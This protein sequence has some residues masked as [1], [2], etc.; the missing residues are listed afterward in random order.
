MTALFTLDDVGLSG[1]TAA[2]Q[3]LVALPG[4]IAAAGDQAA[5]V[6]LSWAVT[7][8]CTYDKVLFRNTKTAKYTDEVGFSTQPLDQVLQDAE[9]NSLQFLQ[10]FKALGAWATATVPRTNIRYAQT[11]A[12]I[13]AVQTAQAGGAPASD[14]QRSQVLIALTE[15]VSAL[16]DGTTQLHPLVSAFATYVLQQKGYLDKLAGVQAGL[17]QD[18]SA[19]LEAMVGDF[20]HEPCGQSDAQAQLDVIEGKYRASVASFDQIFTELAGQ[21]QAATNAAGVLIGTIENFLDSYNVA[22]TQVHDAVA[23]QLGSVLQAFHFDVS[24]SAWQALAQYA[25]TQLGS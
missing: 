23:G 1:A 11:A 19:T 10:Q 14:Q 18:I 8:T 16:Q 3:T 13:D 25:S 12:A 6:P 2:L 21:T 5:A 24:R 9:A 4:E 15:L 20:A 7:V 22:I 17:E